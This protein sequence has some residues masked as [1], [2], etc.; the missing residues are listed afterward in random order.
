LHNFIEFGVALFCTDVVLV[1]FCSLFH[2]D[3]CW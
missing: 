2:L 3:Y 1:F